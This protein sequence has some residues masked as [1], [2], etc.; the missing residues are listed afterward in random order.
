MTEVHLPRLTW[1][2][3]LLVVSFLAA[4]TVWADPGVITAQVDITALEVELEERVRR[5]P[6]DASAWRLLGRARLQR[7][8][9]SGAMNALQT[10]ISL[11]QLSAAA[12]H[13]YAVVLQEMG[14]PQQAAQALAE[15]LLLAPE[16][17]YAGSARKNLDQ[18]SA[19]GVVPASYEVRSFDGSNDAPLARDPRDEEEFDSFFSSLKQD[20]DLRIDLGTQWNDNVSLTPSSR[21]ILAGSLSSAQANAS[22]SARYIAYS[23]EQ[24][25]FGPTL[26]VD[27][28]LNEGHFD[29]LNLQSYRSGAFADAIFEWD[30]IKIK[31]RVA[32]SYTHDLFGGETFGRRH[33]LS[34]SVGIVWTP[35]QISTAYWSIDTNNIKNRRP[36]PEL[37][38]QDGVSNTIGLLHDYVR[39]ESRWRTFR[40]GADLSHVDAEGSNYRYNAMSVFTQSVF[41]IVPKLHL[42]TKGGYAYRDYY[43]FTQTP[44]RDTHVFRTGV[45][46]RK[47]FDTGIS[48]ALVSQY[49]VF[50]TRNDNYR[51]DRFLAGG[52][53]TWEY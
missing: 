52:V 12:F 6:T 53:L 5:D 51:S 13:D 35:T 30:D 36:N 10:A 32:Y 28:T 46:L 7:S 45:E 16:S 41:V 26:D 21:E 14:E 22:L 43:D 23:S 49:D 50:S 24:F 9:W 44:G 3:I 20:L 11:D 15:V 40:I 31:P 34:S 47:Y 37:T 25:R 17:E 48:A 18:L 39:K 1:Q 38:S 33:T 4:T 2:F 19:D 27:Y 29:N 8:D 42:T